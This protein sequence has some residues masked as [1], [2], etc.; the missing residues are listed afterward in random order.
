MGNVFYG[1]LFNVISDRV[2]A[3]FTVR[4]YHADGTLIDE[5]ARDDA[6]NPLTTV[7]GQSRLVTLD[8]SGRHIDDGT[9]SVSITPGGWGDAF[10]IEKPIGR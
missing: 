9:V 3:P 6:G 8:Y 1:P 2:G 4:V 10:P 5:V 7:N